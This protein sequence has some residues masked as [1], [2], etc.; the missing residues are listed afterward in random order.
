MAKRA[1]LT[2]RR[3][4][5]TRRG[6]KQI[7][8]QDLS[9]Y[10]TAYGHQ[11][12][13]GQRYR[14]ILPYVVSI[15][16]FVTVLYVS[17]P[18]SVVAF[19]LSSLLCWGAVL[20]NETY[21]S[22]VRSAYTER[23]RALNLMS[24]AL[25]GDNA[26]LFMVLKQTVPSLRGELKQ[27]FKLL[28]G[29]VARSASREEIHDWFQNEISKYRDDI[30]FG[31]FLE[32][33]ET[34]NLEGIY[35]S[36]TF[37]ELTHY[38]NDLFNKQMEYIRKREQ[39]KR[40]VFTIVIVTFGLICTIAVVVQ[41]WST[42][43]KTY[44]HSPAGMISSTLFLII[45]GIIIRNFLR[46][47]YDESLTTW[48]NDK[49]MQSVAKNSRHRSDI[50]LRKQQAKEVISLRLPSADDPLLVEDDDKTGFKTPVSRRKN[51]K[52]KLVK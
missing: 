52:R 47:Y 42:W 45:Y 18:L 17:V 12:S 11:L 14:K 39:A 5:N 31:Q 28:Q 30:V 3:I 36:S 1:S 19:L 21:V 9:A 24:Q 15:T 50:N 35:S 51:R 37:L 34:M 43:I 27:E 13:A 25:G 20:S 4:R 40:E 49:Q 26:T 2:K 44:A 22:Y 33:L 48:G 41:G 10:E 38:H 7:T 46:Y 8:I 23:N 32:Q 16:A 29:L 6:K